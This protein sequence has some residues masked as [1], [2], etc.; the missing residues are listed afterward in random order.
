MD[1]HR[2]EKLISSR[3][4]KKKKNLGDHRHRLPGSSYKTKRRTS[5]E[6][7]KSGK[8][9]EIS[10]EKSRMTVGNKGRATGGGEPRGAKPNKTRGGDRRQRSGRTNQDREKPGICTR[11]GPDGEWTKRGKKKC[12]NIRQCQQ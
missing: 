10:E 3:K 5:G 7:Q 8:G 11:G 9:G 4:N 6:K 12:R 2:K 1:P